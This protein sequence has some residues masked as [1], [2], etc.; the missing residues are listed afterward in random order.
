[1]LK[2]LVS[3]CISVLLISQSICDEFDKSGKFRLLNEITKHYRPKSN[4][5]LSSLNDLKKIQIELLYAKNSACK[6]RSDLEAY[7]QSN[8]NS[9][10]AYTSLFKNLTQENE[11]QIVSMFNNYVRSFL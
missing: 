5:S 2:I 7:L 8:E 11:N 3:F 1:M 6:E 10:L 9:Y 4:E